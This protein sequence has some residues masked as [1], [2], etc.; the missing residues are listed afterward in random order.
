MDQLRRDIGAADQSRT[1]RK[2]A[3]FARRRLPNLLDSG[4]YFVF[5]YYWRSNKKVTG[6]SLFG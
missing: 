1:R 3:F 4:S 2:S 6:Y 5:N